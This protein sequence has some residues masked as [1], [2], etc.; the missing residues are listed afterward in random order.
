MLLAEACPALL[1]KVGYTCL[2]SEHGLR[3]LVL[4]VIQFVGDGMEPRPMIIPSTPGQG[5]GGCGWGL[6]N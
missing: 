1:S 2:Q 4:E 5:L 3:E 6:S